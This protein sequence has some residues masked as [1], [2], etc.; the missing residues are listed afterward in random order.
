MREHLN[1]KTSSQKNLDRLIR[2][3]NSTFM[4]QLGQAHYQLWL[5]SSCFEQQ[6]AFTTTFFVCFSSCDVQASAYQKFC[7]ADLLVHNTSL[8]HS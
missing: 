1:H 7:D 2:A 3:L 4:S 8:L 6:N 5:W